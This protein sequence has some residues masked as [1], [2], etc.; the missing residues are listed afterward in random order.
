MRSRIRIRTEVK[1][2][3]RIRIK[4][5]RIRNPALNNQFLKLSYMIIMLGTPVLTFRT[6]GPVNTVPVIRNLIR[7]MM[8][9]YLFFKVKNVLAAVCEGC[10]EADPVLQI[11]LN[12]KEEA[13]F[14]YS[15]ATKVLFRFE[16]HSRRPLRS[17]F[18]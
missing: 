1:I 18:R 3:I 17:Q 2:W 14:T 15:D 11:L 16:I 10:K 9:V 8:T 12:K 4:V 7:R 5:M 6:V 13:L